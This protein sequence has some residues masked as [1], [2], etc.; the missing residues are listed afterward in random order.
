LARLEW[1]EARRLLSVYY[2]YDVVAK[3]GDAVSP[4]GDTITSFEPE[5]SINDDGRVAFV[6]N[7]TG[8]VGTGT[9]VVTGDAVNPL[10]KVSFQSVASGRRYSF[11]QIANDNQVLAAESISDS[12]FI[13]TWDATAATPTNTILVRDSETAPD[14]FLPYDFVILPSRANDGGVAYV[15][16]VGDTLTDL[17]Y[18]KNGSAESMIGLSGG[19]YR[20][21]AADGGRVVIRTGV[22]GMQKIFVLTAGGAGQLLADS[23]GFSA[24]SQPGISDD[25]NVIAFAGNNTT[26]GKGIYLSYFDGTKFTTPVKVAGVQNELGYDAAGNGLFL[27][28]FDFSTTD[29]TS[30]LSN[31]VG[32]V[33]GPDVGAAGIEDDT[34]LLTFI[35]T[36]SGASRAN[37]QVPAKPLLFSANKGIWT[38]RIVPAVPPRAVGSPKGTLN[39]NFRTSPMP[40]VQVG[41]TIGG[42]AVTGFTL[43][44]PVATA[45]KDQAGVARPTVDPGDHFVTFD[46]T[47]ASGDEVVRAAQ[48]DTDGDGLY[49]HWER[50]AGGIDIDQ[51][52]TVDLDLSALGAD[53][54]HKD[55]FMEIDWL[56]PDAATGR[57]FSPQKE[58]LDFFDTAMRNA[59]LTNPDGTTGVSVHIDAGS[60]I[61]GLSRNMG[62]IA[63][64]GGDLISQAGTGNHIHVLYF[65]TTDPVAAL[66]GGTDAVGRPF[67]ARSLES[68]KQ[69][70]FGTT[71]K[72]ARELAFKYVVFADSHGAGMVGGVVQLSGSSGV[73]EAGVFNSAK[74]GTGKQIDTRFIPGNDAIIS[75]G[76]ARSWVGGRLTVPTPAV[77]APASIPEPV[78]FLQGQTLLHEVGHTLGLLHGGNDSLTSGPPTAVTPALKPNYRSLMNYAYQLHPDPTGALVRD[79]SRAGDAVFADWPVVQLNFNAFF[80]NLGNSPNIRPRYTSGDDAPIEQHD[81]QDLRDAIA[82]NGPL[83]SQVPSVKVDDPAD[84]SNLAV[85]GTLTVKLTATDNVGIDTLKVSFDGDGDGVLSPGETID[86]TSLGGGKY[87]AVF[88]NI[89]GPAGDRTLTATATDAATFTAVANLT[90]SVTTIIAPP[91]KVTAATFTFAALPQRITFT[92]SQNVSASL[93]AGDFDIR[94]ADGT[95]APVTPTLLPYDAVNNMQTL[96]LPGVPADGR[97]VVT[98]SSAGIGNLNGQLDGNGDGSPGPDYTFA[99]LFFAGDANNDGAVDFNDLVMLAQNYNTTGGRTFDQG[100]FNYDGN[101]DFNDLVILAQRYNTQ[102]PPAAAAT[103]TGGGIFASSAGARQSVFAQLEAAERRAPQKVNKPVRREGQPAPRY[104]RR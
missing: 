27:N 52:G 14:G 20:P 11:P 60:S 90:I 7:V 39:F 33:H 45:K 79:Y 6:A 43:Y 83:D 65:G 2:D 63:L 22:P 40:V 68:V 49:D 1:L 26:T 102:L 16:E 10:K 28:D 62:G 42:R 93:A 18:K 37:P 30:N 103:P 81:D 100:D 72:D 57:D 3:A 58:A 96:T 82:I 51:D 23:S 61:P 104:P 36:P 99:F 4:D 54:K 31:R 44:D 84:H 87:Q 59:P 75:V 71:T 8:G 29:P 97:Y 73:A 25:G 12:T 101:V 80:D 66:G 91:P 95:G 38:M 46:A 86:A 88:T 48:L 94:R 85:G 70:F 19:G 35:G 89:S 67:V 78:G 92:F 98:L 21:M 53:P 76:G 15:G 50:A 69:T 5:T 24:L 32:V 74:D 41:D 55:L 56:K 9:A 17:Y 47:T 13:R 77:G 64:Q 34:I